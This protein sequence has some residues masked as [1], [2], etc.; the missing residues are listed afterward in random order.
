MNKLYPNSYPEYQTSFFV[1]C[2]EHHTEE[3]IKDICKSEKFS[4]N[5]KAYIHTRFGNIVYV[6]IFPLRGKEKPFENIKK[7]FIK[8]LDTVCSYISIIFDNQTI[9]YMKEISESVYFLERE[10]RILIE[11]IF[12]REIGVEWYKEYFQSKEKEKDRTKGRNAILQYLKNPLDSLDFVHLKDFVEN[13]IKF[14]KNTMSD[15]LE[16]IENALNSIESTT[17]DVQHLYEKALQ[18]LEEIRK[19]SNFK[20]TGLGVSKLYQ[21]ITSELA[22]EW[23]DLYYSHRNPW[24]HN[25]FLMT[26][27][28]LEKYKELATSVLKKI[29]TEITLLSLLEDGIEFKM[30]SG[31]ISLSLTNFSKFGAS[32][33]RLKLQIKSD[34]QQHI[35]EIPEASYI[36]LFTVL[37]KLTLFSE[38][39]DCEIN[40]DYLKLNP[41]LIN[42][43]KNYCER[44]FESDSLQ[45][46]IDSDFENLAELLLKEN[47]DYRLK[48]LEGT[49][50]FMKEDVDTLLKEIFTGV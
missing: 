42:E 21:H 1:V 18:T 3:T 5:I 32:F 15:K 47:S 17:E 7:D 8:S 16:A 37:E 25:H 41:F 26:R 44:L 10:F 29:R 6:T 24:A 14:S 30:Q 2:K 46:K 43:L 28:E 22:N 12:L 49:L 33:C 50:S 39:E 11:I 31:N 13:R 34:N 27:D 40:L 35:L 36:E 48:K 23:Q 20:R 19:I 45:Q 9:N 4:Q 38:Y